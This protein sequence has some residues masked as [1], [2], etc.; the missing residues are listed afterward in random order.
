MLLQD[1]LSILGTVVIV[2]GTF[3]LFLAGRDIYQSLLKTQEALCTL[4][5]HNPCS[6]EHLESGDEMQEKMKGAVAV[7]YTEYVQNSFF[8]RHVK[9]LTVAG[10]LCIFAG[11]AM[12][13][14]GTVV[15]RLW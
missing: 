13:I 3:L 5:G 11:S 1:W 8:Q 4:S 2:G 10:L 14:V 12:Q 6:A 9:E 15:A 7:I